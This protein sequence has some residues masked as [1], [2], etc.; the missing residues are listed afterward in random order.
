MSTPL[1]K[2]DLTDLTS[3]G[4]SGSPLMPYVGFL[5]S[6]AALKVSQQV[7]ISLEPFA[8]Q[9]RHYGVLLFLSQINTT[10]SQKE[11][12]ERLWIDRNTMVS[13]IDHLEAQG[14][15]V[16]TRDPK[17]RRSYAISIT[18]KGRTVVQQA[19]QVVGEADA[20]FTEALTSDELEQFTKLLVKLLTG[21][22]G[23]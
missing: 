8:I 19:D 6:K 20:Q 7:D 2:P 22:Q 15:A 16:R 5:L 9:V 4:D 1:S 12:G 10:V 11:I 21:A 17:D 18:E 23:D 3:L 13:L 14:L